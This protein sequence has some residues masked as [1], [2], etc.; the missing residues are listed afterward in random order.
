MSGLV[1]PALSVRSAL[2]AAGIAEVE[3]SREASYSV[4]DLLTVVRAVGHRPAGRLPGV[5]LAST[6]RIVVTTT[7][8]DF[9]TVS[10]RAGLVHSETMSLT[11]F[12][13]VIFSSVTCVSLPTEVGA[14]DPTGAVAIQAEYTMFFRRVQ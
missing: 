5:R 7:G 13:D 12:N 11:A 10:N 3:L 2:Q 8:P 6:A 9:D 1:D 14:H 4:S